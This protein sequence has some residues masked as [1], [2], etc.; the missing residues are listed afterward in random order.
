MKVLVVGAAGKTGRL[1]V[2][3]A[4]AAGHS[5]KALVHDTETLVEHPFAEGVQIVQGDVHD[6]ATV[7]TRGDRMR[8]RYRYA[9]R[10]EA[11]SEDRSGVERRSRRSGCDERR[12]SE[13]AGRHLGA[14]RG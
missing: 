1:V 2:D 4:L 9:W 13:A 5:V 7:R 14:G 3:R 11:L 10:Q 12:R 8:C 6:P